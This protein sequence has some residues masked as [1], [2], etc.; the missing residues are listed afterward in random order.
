M[1][2]PWPVVALW[3]NRQKHWTLKSKARAAQRLEA[4]TIAKKHIPILGEGNIHLEIT[5]H[6]PSRRSFDLDNALAA[7]KGIIDG[8]ADGWKINDKMFR[9]LTITYGEPVSGGCVKIINK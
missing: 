8:I 2:F 5:F 7:S 9:P 4:F 6:P 1:I 3:P